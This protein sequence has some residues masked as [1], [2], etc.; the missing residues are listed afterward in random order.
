MKSG[1]YVRVVNRKVIV[2]NVLGVQVK[3]GEDP[4]AES[5]CFSPCLRVSSRFETILIVVIL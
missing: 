4:V 3:L 5:I 1:H 2:Q